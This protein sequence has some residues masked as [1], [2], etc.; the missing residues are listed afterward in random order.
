MPTEPLEL[1]F[2]LR[3]INDNWAF[4]RQPEGTTP[5]CLNVVPF[6]P[7]DSR[8]RGGQRW[9]LSKYITDAFN[10]TEAIQGIRQAIAYSSSSGFSETFSE[11]LPVCTMTIATP[12]VLT[13]LGTAYATALPCTFTTTGTLP[14]GLVVGTIYYL[15]GTGANTYNLYTT[16]AYATAGGATG[17]IDTTGA[18]AGV[19]T[20]HASS[21]NVYMT[22]NP[23]YYHYYAI[24]TGNLWI[25]AVTPE[26]AITVQ[27]VYKSD[28]LETDSAES[29]AVHHVSKTAVPTGDLYVSFKHTWT[30][31]SPASITRD[32]GVV[33]RGDRATGDGYLLRFRTPA[34]LTGAGDYWWVTFYRKDAGT[35]TTLNGGHDQL[36]FNIQNTSGYYVLPFQTLWSD[37]IHIEIRTSGNDIYVYANG[38]LVTYFLGEFSQFTD[39]T[40][41][42]FISDYTG[43][44]T[45]YAARVDDFIVRSATETAGSSRTNRIVVVSGGNVYDGNK[46]DGKTL[47]TNGAGAMS[48]TGRIGMQPA[49]GKMY[50]CDGVASHYKVYDTLSR[51]ITAWTP[52]DGALPIGDTDPTKACK[53]IALY[54]GR[55]VMAG[56]EEE[57]HNWYMSAAGN[58]L[59]WDYGAT[60][61]ATMAVAGNNTAAGKCPDIITCLA[62]YSDDLMIIG[63]D[64]TLWVM[65][66][67]P[68]DRG[69]IDNISYKTG[70]A[71]PEAFAFDP[72]GIFYFFGAGTLW[73]MAPNGVPESL[74]QNRMDT[75]FGGIDT[76]ASTV[77][78]V[79]D[80][81][82]HGLHIFFTPTT[83]GSATHY[84]W[85]ERTDGFWKITY[86]NAQGPTAVCAYD[87]DSPN[88]NAVLLGGWDS[89]VRYVDPTVK[90]DDST[91]ISSYVLYPP[92]AAGGSLNNTRINGITTVLDT[93]S[94][95]IVLTAYAEDTVQ[96]VIEATTIRFARTLSAGRTTLL[97][98]VAG[99]AIMFRLSNSVDDTTWAIESLMANVET[100]GRTRKNQL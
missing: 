82:R 91:T 47:V 96:R 4:G 55:I 60:P 86:P 2:P 89:Y 42:G 78:L 30:E 77:Q 72:N 67:D 22:A 79:W 12:C 49:Y 71:G 5:D 37:T 44:P 61:S 75:V 14:T 73:R 98:R 93:D 28:T 19:H 54:R 40:E 15:R 11:V 64:H 50:F 9:G 7:L 97:N 74:S 45:S 6:D 92:I 38:V 24:Q 20:I 63:G 56:L 62:P 3:G 43:F 90:T 48:A 85:D 76:S 35:S 13:V 87:G 18:Q 29:H 94:N 34:R 41:V 69:R 53:I 16:A 46:T 100:T 58:P 68:A 26:T 70:I 32:F 17:R 51:T 83:S 95:D 25:S 99:N 80:T 33:L 39:H 36:L 66:G 84:Y 23:N 1:I 88:D 27:S 52:T 65:R 81:V 21:E 57:P 8:A 59:D 10:G 31:T